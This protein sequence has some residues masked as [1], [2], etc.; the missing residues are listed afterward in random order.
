MVIC[1]CMISPCTYSGAWF[2]YINSFSALA[3]D[4]HLFRF[5]ALL[6]LLSKQMMYLCLQ[7]FRE[8][9][10]GSYLIFKNPFKGKAKSWRLLLGSLWHDYLFVHPLQERFSVILF[11]ILLNDHQELCRDTAVTG[12]WR[13][14]SWS[15]WSSAWMGK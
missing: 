10:F 14:G 8:G 9:Y 1:G 4:I 6:V 7:G 5:L 15:L 3:S 13:N 12:V 2:W 11:L